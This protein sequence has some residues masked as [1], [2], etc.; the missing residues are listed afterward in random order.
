MNWGHLFFNFSG[1]INRAKYWVA[2]LIYSAI[3]IVLAIV[4]YLTDN[5]AIYQAINGMLNI[6]IFISSLAVGVKRLHDRNKSGWYLVLFYIVP[7]ILVTAG[8][9]VG[10]FMDDSILLASILGLAAFAIGVWAFVEL[11][12]LRG[13][14]G[15]NRCG[16]DPLEPTASPPVRT[17][18]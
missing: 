18:A 10:T 14:I 1:R 5:S 6:V 4:G 12:C 2:M 13:T 9:V 8:I 15:P 16:P 11:G 17:S 7:G 3:Y